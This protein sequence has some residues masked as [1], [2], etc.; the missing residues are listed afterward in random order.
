[1][2]L[3]LRQRVSDFG[4]PFRIYVL[5]LVSLLVAVV[6]SILP[7]LSSFLNISLPLCFVNTDSDNSFG[8]VAKIQAGKP[9]N[10]GIV[11][12]RVRD[13]CIF[14]NFQTGSGDPPP[15]QLLIQWIPGP[16]YGG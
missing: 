10:G 2:Y 11:T 16:L 7:P 14:H 5:Y 15:Q 6:S 13:F 3:I 12:V 1:V 4:L 9:K 8:R